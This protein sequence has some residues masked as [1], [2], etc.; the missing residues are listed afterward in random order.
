MNSQKS[1]LSR[2]EEA[3]FEIF[4]AATLNHKRGRFMLAILLDTGLIPNRDTI[5]MVTAKGQRYN[6]L[7][8]LVDEEHSILFKYLDLPDTYHTLARYEADTKA[9]VIANLYI[10]AQLSTPTMIYEYMESE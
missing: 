5:K 7:R 6:F 9:Q 3:F 1:T 8:S 2:Q 10:S 4:T